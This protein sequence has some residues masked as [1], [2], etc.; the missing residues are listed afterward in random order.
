MTK[1]NFDVN[2]LI[3]KGSK[4]KLTI[5]P[6][7]DPDDKA[8]QLRQEFWTYVVKELL[9]YGVGFRFLIGIGGYRCYVVVHHGVVSAE[10]RMVFPLITT[11]FGG[12]L[13]MI[14]GKAGK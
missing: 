6:P 11:L 2:V 3:Q 7:E 4:A 8:A 5:E 9:A 13:G 1:S 12:V 14:V 10:A